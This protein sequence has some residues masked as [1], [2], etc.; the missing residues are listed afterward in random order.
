MDPSSVEM[1][2]RFGAVDAQGRYLHWD[3][4]RHRLPRDVSPQAVWSAVKIARLVIARWLPL[5]AANGSVFRY[6]VTDSMQQRLHQIDR[7]CGP[8]LDP[9]AFASTSTQREHYFVASLL[10]EEAITS[11][12]LEGAATTR[13]AAKQMLETERPPRDEHE[14]MIVNNY[15]LMK[16]ALN[17]REEELSVDLI[18]RLH[19]IATRGTENPMVIPGMLRD[20]DDVIVQ[21]QGG[22]VVHQPPPAA[23]LPERLQALCDFAN[24]SHDGPEAFIHPCVKAVI[25]HFMLAYE[26]PFGDGN[27]RTARALFYWYMLKRG[28]WPFEYISISSLLRKA[29]VQY[30]ISYL[31]TETDEFDLTY[32]VDYQIGIVERAIAAFLAHIERKKREFY[33]L[34]QWLEATGIQNQLN[35]RQGQLLR[36]AI[37]HPGRAFTV[38]E[39]ANDFDVTENTARADLKKLAKLRM[40]AEVQEGKTALFLARADIAERLGGAA[41]AGVPRG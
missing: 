31:Y 2:H 7:L 36:K 15:L 40:L 37:R 14:R 13:K 25:L 16:E 4:L 20:S 19:S 39:V 11:A 17:S 38:K 26:H 35:F 5:K 21:G 1:L 10:M 18:R 3:Q 29:P 6:A 8:R 30:G 33:E 22:E 12:Q 34:M 41:Q 23:E 24:A 9:A 27:G 32:F 28:Y